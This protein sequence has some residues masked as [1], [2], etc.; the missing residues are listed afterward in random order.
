MNSIRKYAIVPVLAL[1]LVGAGLNMGKAA[2]SG[3]NSSDSCVLKAVGKKNTYGNPDS[4]WTVKDGVA[5]LEVTLTGKNCSSDVT[6]VSWFAPD[7]DKGLP[8]SEQKLDSYNTKHMA[9]SKD[10]TSVSAT[11]SIAVPDCYFQLDL[12][13][14]SN[15]TDENGGPEYYKYGNRHVLASLHGGT[16][17]C[18]TPVDPPAVP[19][20]PVQELPKTGV[21]TNAILIA[22][23]SAVVGTIVSWLYQARKQ[24]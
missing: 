19:A 4:R 3:S 9:T 1:T 24:S 10:D 15:P 17:A 16:V 8:Y 7:G 20:K 22:S 21:G 12:I 13:P 11:M 2:A 23:F 18:S 5:S 14:G 6:I